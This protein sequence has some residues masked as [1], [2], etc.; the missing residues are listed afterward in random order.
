[1]LSL[2]V[3]GVGFTTFLIF[4][5]MLVLL[6][7]GMPLSFLTGF[8]AMFVTLGWFGPSA[9]GMIG[10]RIFSFVTEYSLVSIPMFVLMASLLDQSGVAKDLYNTM[11]VIAG[12]LKGG[13]AV[14]TVVVA[15][16]L[17]AMSGI[18]G[19]ETVLLGM[20]ALPQMLRLGYNKNLAIGTVVAGGTLGTMIPPSIVL[21]MYGMT[22]GVSIS[23]LFKA[24][25]TPGLILVT[26]FISY[27]LIRCYLNPK[28]G[29]PAPQPEV[30]MTTRE[31]FASIGHIL[32]P[33]SIIA[34]VLGSIYGGIASVTE[35]ACM[36]VIG[37]AISAAI[38][39]EL[40]FKIVRTSLRQTMQTCGMIIWIGIGASAVVGV[41][42][43]IGGKRFV[44]A[45]ILGMDVAPIV[46]I[47][48]MMAILLVM[49]MFFD[50]IGIVM[51]TMPIF[52]PII[53]TLGYDPLWFGIVFCVN[54]QVSFL[55]PPFGTAA[56]YLK[57]V[58]PQ[59]VSL[60]DIYKSVWPFIIM[61]LIT[62]AIVVMYP[63]VVLWII[64]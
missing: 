26:L 38:R 30:P 50:W 60:T 19:G 23:D 35:A 2:S 18:V 64:H 15:A 25:I 9:V 63:E 36:G 58:A 12:R 57:S 49:G 22:A 24:A 33:M 28:L 55:S 47:L 48:V 56:F 43:L 51:L 62:L 52:V 1:M 17:A 39:K 34:W 59:E 46:I 32:L 21:I 54:M 11:R 29:P 14:Q 42:N 7:I 3:A 45:A 10:A 37:V 13:V 5:M 53:K 27:I 6:V 41:Y 40:N 16:I 61:Q 20:L 4:S 8:V 31:K 44:E